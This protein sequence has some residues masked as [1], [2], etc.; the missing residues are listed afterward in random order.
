MKKIKGTARTNQWLYEIDG[1]LF[2][3]VNLVKWPEL[4]A[5]PEG[6]HFEEIMA[7]AYGENPWE[8]AELHGGE[9]EMLNRFR[10]IYQGERFIRAY[11]E[12]KV[13]RNGQAKE[14]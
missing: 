2:S 6:S 1:R 4:K 9:T 10:F 3:L 7:S 8:V 14:L 5:M 13:D 12:G 11:V